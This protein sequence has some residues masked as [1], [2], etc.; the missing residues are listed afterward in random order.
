MKPVPAPI[1]VPLPRRPL[2][3]IP[4]MD[5]ATSRN[6]TGMSISPTGNAAWFCQ[7]HVAAPPPAAPPTRPAAKVPS[8]VRVPRREC[9]CSGFVAGGIPTAAV[10]VGTA[11]SALYAGDGCGRLLI[12][13]LPPG[14]LIAT[15]SCRQR[16][17]PSGG[18][19]LA[20]RVLILSSLINIKRRARTGKHLV[21]VSL[22]VG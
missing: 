11:A 19:C 20:P 18:L 1:P 2:T 14:G 13:S 7:Y 15:S 12:V 4:T 9:F 8:R 16:R 22:N 10:A 21:W 17:L 6:S 5:G 3:S